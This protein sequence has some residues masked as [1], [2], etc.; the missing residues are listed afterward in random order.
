[1]TIECFDLLGPIAVPI[2]DNMKE[3]TRKNLDVAHFDIAKTAGTPGIRVP[4][5]A[6]RAGLTLLLLY[7]I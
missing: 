6:F 7:F 5:P 4:A 3:S 1:M 2:Y